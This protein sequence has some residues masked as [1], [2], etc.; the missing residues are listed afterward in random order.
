VKES[1][2]LKWSI[3]IL[4]LSAFLCGCLSPAS[5]VVV[6]PSADLSSL[7][8]VAA[9]RFRDGG[10]VENSGDITTRAIE[11]A[12][13]AKGFRLVAYSKIRDIVS[14]EVGFQE[15]MALDAGMLTPRVLER[16]REETGV[17]ALILG[18]VSDAWCDPM[19][20]PSCWIECSFQ[21]ID[22]KAGE[23]LIS[24]NV[25]DDGWSLQSAA[26]QTAEK[27]INKIRR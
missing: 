27:A 18:S 13:M 26:N 24:A 22:T 2:K 5:H 14:V 4:F 17:D 20:M 23:I 16:I 11:S 8:K 21:M 9:W 19:W 7:K 15:G 6:S 12:L 1:E 3:L 25:S 10:R